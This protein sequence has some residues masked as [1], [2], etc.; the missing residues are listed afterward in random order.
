[1]EINATDYCASASHFLACK[2]R[3]FLTLSN[4]HMWRRSSLLI[5]LVATYISNAA[6]VAMGMYC[7]GGIR[8]HRATVSVA[9]TWRPLRLV[10]RASTQVVYLEVWEEKSC[11][12]EHAQGIDY[13]CGP[14]V[15][16]HIA[17]PQETT[18]AQTRA[19]T[20]APN[21]R[22]TLKYGKKSPASASTPNALM[23]AAALPV[24]PDLMLSAV[25]ASAAVAGTPPRHP[26]TVLAIARP[27]TSFLCDA[28]VCVYV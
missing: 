15:C 28:C 9:W 18:R 14:A 24:A 2:P 11:Q 1:M 17:L 7:G 6:T 10:M 8:T 23:M 16:E 12:R 4:C 27:R 13:G 19:G 22:Y 21:V 3:D 5:I 26:A 20:R 25:R